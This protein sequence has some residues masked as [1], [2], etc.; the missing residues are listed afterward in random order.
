MTNQVLIQ[1]FVYICFHI[2]LLLK[3]STVI[4]V[5]ENNSFIRLFSE[6]SVFLKK[7][8]VW[9]HVLPI[10]TRRSRQVAML[11]LSER[12]HFPASAV[13]APS[14]SY[15]VQIQ[16]MLWLL[17]WWKR[18]VPGKNEEHPS[19]LTLSSRGALNREFW[20]YPRGPELVWR[21]CGDKPRAESSSYG[22]SACQV[23]GLPS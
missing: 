15:L 21:C 10:C 3:A 13:R 5:M 2:R 7:P 23:L 4:R 19:S 11:Q 12:H 8:Y 17:C 14:K 22:V 20:E 18:P 9:K 6:I 1:S 16:K